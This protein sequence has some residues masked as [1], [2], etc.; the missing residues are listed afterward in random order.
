L[1]LAALAMAP[2]SGRPQTP[3]PPPSGAVVLSL[4]P[5]DSGA[6]PAGADTVIDVGAVAATPSGA[7]LQP[8]VIRRRI[9]VQI[10]VPKGAASSARLSV[11]LAS[12]FP[13]TTTRVDGL[14]VSTVPRMIAPAHR[15]GTPIVHE[16]ELTIP[17][18]APSGAFASDLTWLVE[19]D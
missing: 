5:L 11:A 16:V 19:I 3:A 10:D 7:R 9:G 2:A 18:G 12:E 17:R 13:G 1:L 6:G 14:T 4:I 8:I 15:V